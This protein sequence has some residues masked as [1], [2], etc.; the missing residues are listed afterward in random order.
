MLR[1]LAGLSVVRGVWSKRPVG[2]GMLV[3]SLNSPWPSGTRTVTSTAWVDWR[4]AYP[5]PQRHLLFSFF[6]LLT[7]WG[8]QRGVRA[9]RYIWVLKARKGS[10]NWSSIEHVRRSTMNRN[11]I[12]CRFR[13]RLTIRRIGGW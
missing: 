3:G 8:G 4:T 1:D 12:S 5:S 9:R 10:L 11:R 2:V 13:L 6:F 7:F